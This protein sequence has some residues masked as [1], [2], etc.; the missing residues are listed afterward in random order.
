MPINFTESLAERSE[1][2]RLEITAGI[3]ES[4]SNVF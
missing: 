3:K 2:G 1:E 4:E